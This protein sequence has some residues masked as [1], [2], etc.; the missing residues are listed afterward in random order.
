[1]KRMLAMMLALLMMTAGALADGGDRPVT[2]VYNPDPA[3]R[4]NLRISPDKDAPSI[5]KYYT[6]AEVVVLGETGDGWA[7]VSTGP[8]DGYMDASFLRTAEDESAVVSAMPTVTI[9]NSGGTGANVRTKPGEDGRVFAL[10][11]NGLQMKVRCVT[12]DG[13]LHVI[14]DGADGF[15]RADLASPRLYFDTTQTGGGS[16]AVAGT[17]GGDVAIVSTTSAAE[18][19]NLRTAPDGDAPSLCK[20]YRGV[21]VNLLSGEEDG[22]YRVDIGGM[23][24]YVKGEFIAFGTHGQAQAMS[25]MP[26]VTART[27]NTPVYAAMNYNAAKI[28]TLAKGDAVTVMGVS[29]DYLHVRLT[30]GVTGF[31][32][33]DDMTP[34]LEFDLS[35]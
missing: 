4:L 14:V 33:T 18:R 25:A 9:A 13:W 34:E 19:L 15:I 30:S 6:G 26:T 29:T 2:Y 7:F 24:G 16:S 31:V 12:P 21:V 27:N 32:L 3:D 35:K 11:T 5:A 8:L 20:Y 1:M 17:T 28:E 10:L 23:Q 22:W